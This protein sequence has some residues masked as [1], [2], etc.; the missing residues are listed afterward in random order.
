MF[1]YVCQIVLC[2]V[3]TQAMFTKNIVSGYPLNYGFAVAKFICGVVL[4]WMC[5][6]RIRQGLD[7]MKFSLNHSYRFA[8]PTIAFCVAFMQL[9]VMIFIE[10]VNFFNL[11]QTTDLFELLRDFTA[12]LIVADFDIL[13]YG[14]LK[15][16]VMKLLLTDENFKNV[17]LQ[18]SRTTSKRID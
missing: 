10:F 2:L 1:I 6:S 3:L 7:C 5:Q 15:D 18:I 12:L 8:T 16:E 9:S 17:C 14:S 4:H 11:L 13:L